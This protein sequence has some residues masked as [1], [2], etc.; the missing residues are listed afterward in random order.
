MHHYAALVGTSLKPDSGTI[1]HQFWGPQPG[2]V[3]TGTEPG[4]PADPKPSACD[5]G[6]FGKGTGGELTYSVTLPAHGS[7]T[8]WLAVAGSDNGLADARQQLSQVL[9][10]PAEALEKKI[11][12]RQQLASQTQLSLPGDPQLAAAVDWG[13]Q[14]L[15]DLTLS[16]RNLQIRWTNQG[17]Q[18]PAPLGTVLAGD[19]DRRRFPRL[20]LDIRHR[21]RVHRVR[22]GVR[23]P[24]LR[25]RESP[26]RIA[27]RLR[28][29]EQPIGRGGAR[30][31]VR[32][33][34]LVRPRFADDQS[35]RHED[36]RLQHR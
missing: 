18:F 21:R 22:R 11:D 12:S 3:C 28:H 27:G 10:E 4:A 23:R 8:V 1:G 13:K 5:D 30:D 31:G 7:R 32:R 26:A 20:S 14:N 9:H 25:D 33:L 35:R 2:H 16:A 19:L 17:K 36:Q 24:V 6:P 15:A 29:P 34:G